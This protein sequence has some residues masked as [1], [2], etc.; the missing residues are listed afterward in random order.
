MTDI[1]I[2][3]KTHKRCKI[4]SY[5]TTSRTICWVVQERYFCFNIFKNKSKYQFTK[6]SSLCP[7][8]SILNG[9]P[10]AHPKPYRSLSYSTIVNREDVFLKMTRIM[11]SNVSAF[12][13]QYERSCQQT[14]A[15]STL[16]LSHEKF[17]IKKEYVSSANQISMASLEMPQTYQVRQFYSTGHITTLLYPSMAK[18]N[19]LLKIFS[20]TESQGKPIRANA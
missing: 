4:H 10:T 14:S 20:E 2:P 16:V 3:L 17:R 19:L 6:H 12:T 18:E 15:V 11:H 13:R 8:S 9:K 7:T 1:F 5:V